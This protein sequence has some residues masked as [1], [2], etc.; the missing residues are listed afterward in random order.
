MKGL[1]LKDLY[2]I[3]AS[4]L[5]MV[6]AVFVMLAVW[7]GDTTGES[8]FLL[9]YAV[10]LLGIIPA[11]LI[12]YEIA[13][14]WIDY[15]FGL[16][17]D[18]KVLVGEKYVL[19]LLAV[20]AVEALTAAAYGISYFL[21]GV[22][23]GPTLGFMMVEIVVVILFVN[24]I[25]MPLAYRFG[26]EKSRIVYFLLFAIYGLILGATGRMLPGSSGGMVS[27]AQLQNSAAVTPAKVMLVLLPIALALYA[28]SWRVSVAWYG[29]YKK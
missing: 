5:G 21:H 15:S 29:K 3:R 4:M 10:F 6:I 14:G 27:L 22:Q 18:K 17:L 7:C 2:Q 25:F 20:A 23:H 24:S 26:S 1:I 9:N 11:F 28:V 19:G 13:Y 16:P 12:S 8:A